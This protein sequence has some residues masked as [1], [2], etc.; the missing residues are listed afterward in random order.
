ML[1]KEDIREYARALWFDDTGFTGPEAFGEQK[2]ILQ[3]RME[4]YAWAMEMG[5]DLIG[6]TDP[7]SILPGA[8]SIIV[9]METYF[10]EGFPPAMER[11][12]GRCYLDDDREIGRAHV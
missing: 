1:K 5:L 2:K 7:S 8:A 6:G 11:Y 3:E 9:L 4:G 12:F 10:R